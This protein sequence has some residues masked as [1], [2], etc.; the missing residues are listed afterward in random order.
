M[1][2]KEVGKPVKLIWTREEDIQHDFYRPIAMARMKATLDADGMP[3]AW[4][5]RLSGQSIL[6]T[7]APEM[8][9]M[10]GVDGQ[11]MHGFLDDMP[12]EVANYR[13]DYAM[14][15]SHV[16]VGAWRAVN[17][18]QNTFFKECFIDELAYAA[19][20]DTYKYR[21]RLLSEKPRY[22]AVLDAAAEQANWGRP[23]KD[24]FQGIAINEAAGSICAQVVEVSVNID[25]EVRV[26]RVVSAID[27][28]HIVNPLTVELQTESAVA[29]ALS[30]AL[31]GEITVQ[32]GRVEQSNFHDYRMLRMSEMPKVETVIVPSDAG[33]GGIGEPPVAPLAPALCNAI[34]AATGTRIRSLPIRSEK[35]RKA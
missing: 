28:G 33:W 15:N 6:A 3:T 23:Q 16:P 25:G 29:Y 21:R 20:A 19:G 32:D 4:Q 17:Q 35:L 26:H 12:Y 31:Y 24:H 11:F 34:F 22:L 10:G 2:A 30:A 14:R 27:A 5:I 1:I 9:M 7:I 8:M 18:S 13:V